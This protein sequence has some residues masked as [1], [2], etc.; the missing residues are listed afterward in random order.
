MNGSDHVI[1][2]HEVNGLM[3]FTIP[4][5]RE[6]CVGADPPAHIQYLYESPKYDRYVNCYKFYV[7][8]SASREVRSHACLKKP[9][10][11]RV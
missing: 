6:T 3:H 11:S 1:F 7:F 9:G 2:Y 10:D 8:M 4:W 5:L